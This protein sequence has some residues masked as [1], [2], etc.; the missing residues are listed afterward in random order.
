[1]DVTLGNALSIVPHKP[2]KHCTGMVL[3][4][5]SAHLVE[6][7]KSVSHE[8]LADLDCP[9]H[10]ILSDEIVE[11]LAFGCISD[12]KRSRNTGDRTYEFAPPILD[13][14]QASVRPKVF[15]DALSK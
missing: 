14:G 2:F 5:I 7:T 6:R 13:V 12:V 11:D 9:I 3:D 4:W 10:F 8:I 15:L 1:V